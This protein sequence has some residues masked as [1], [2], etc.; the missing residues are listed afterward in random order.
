MATDEPG[1][2]SSPR[3]DDINQQRRDRPVPL[4]LVFHP[5]DGSDVDSIRPVGQV[6]R[7]GSLNL[8]TF[9]ERDGGRPANF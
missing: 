6:D 3:L 2:V 1:R 4:A 9:T 7:A 5:R 8:A